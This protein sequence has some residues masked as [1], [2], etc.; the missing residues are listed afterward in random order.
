MSHAQGRSRW[1]A[2]PLALA[3]A[4]P[5]LAALPA[6]PASAQGAA[7][8]RGYLS[9]A[10]GG[11]RYLV[12]DPATAQ[13]VFTSPAGAVDGALGHV[14]DA[15]PTVAYVAEDAAHVDR[16]HL[17]EPGAADRVVYT[18]PAGFDVSEPSIAPDGSSVLFCLDD[19]KTSAILSV[20]AGSQAVRTVRRSTAVTYA[21]PSYSPD[22]SHLSWTQASDVKSDV[23]TAAAATG[24][25]TVV[26]SSDF[27][28]YLDSA[29]SPD[30][31]RLLT[32]RLEQEYGTGT[33]VT[34]LELFDLRA[35]TYRVVLRGGTTSSGVMAFGEPT[36]AA[37]GRSFYASK[38]TQ[39]APPS[40]TVTGELVHDS[41]EPGSFADPVPTTAYAGS[42]SVAGPALRDT[43]AP[44]PATGLAASVSGATAHLS[45]TLPADPDLAEVVVTRS[46]GAAADTPTATITVGGTRD[47]TFDV[48]LPAAGTDY[49]ISV[50]TRDWSGNLGPAAQLGVRSPDASVTT[51]ST[52]PSRIAY[53][54]VVR[55]SGQV[56]ANGVGVPGTVALYA[57]RAGTTTPVRVTS[58]ATAADGSYALS[59]T[60]TATAEYQVRFAGTD[61]GYP[62]LS[63]KRVVTVVPKV[64]LAAS[65]SRVLRG[66]TVTLSGSVAPGRSGQVVSIQRYVA[67]AWRTLASTR[68]SSTGAYSYALHPSTRGTWTLRVLVPAGIDHALAVSPTR[69]LTVR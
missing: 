32:V 23:V 42:P 3:L 26:A 16:L 20:D 60:P 69:V 6:A 33:P 27:I 14:T 30:G 59:Y 1:T 45:F 58:V 18:G 68:L 28:Q 43:S 36:W 39:A 2:L 4:V 13:V 64:T 9:D 66:G 56:T 10:A 22:G 17:V 7:E 24:A 21:G 25:A 15:G 47:V 31:S 52:P 49:G 41:I 19:P 57:R 46:V 37:D 44:A 55:L 48:P 8:Y 34:S 61:R 35:G 50:F 67:G 62:S 54:G 38:A 51:V 53:R 12:T 63:A 65:A 40:S 5:L 11:A 29:W